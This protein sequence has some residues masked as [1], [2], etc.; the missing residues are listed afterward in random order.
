MNF[1]IGKRIT[2]GFS[3]V[4]AIAVAL[5][6][7]SYYEMGKVDNCVDAIADD[8]MPG[9]IYAGE[10]NGCTR[11]ANTLVLTHILEDSEGMAKTEKLIEENSR[12]ADGAYSSYEKTITQAED[13][14]NFQ[15]LVDARKVF[16][17]AVAKNIEV[18]RK[19]GV[20]TEATYAFYKKNVAPAYE[21]LRVQLDII[22]DFN[23]KYG[24][25]TASLAV[26]TSNSAQKGILSCIA[27]AAVIGALLAFFIVT[28][29]NRALVK[30]ASE[31]GNG[32]TQTA[33]A[34]GQV[35]SS[36]ESLAAG[37][38]EQASSIEETSASIEEMSSMTKA[39]AEHAAKAEA[40][41]SSAM[42]G[43]EK[44]AAAM[45][46]MVK[47]IGDIKKSSDSTAKI[48]KTIDEIAFQTN[49]LAL[50]AAV[51]AARAGEAGKGF[52]VVAEEVRNLAQ[53]SSD[54]A[55]STAAMIEESVKNTNSGVEISQETEKAL[56]EISELAGKVY[57]FL[58][59]ISRASEEQAKGIA[60]INIAVGE[61]ENVTQS[62]AAGA[63]ESASASEELNAQAEEMRRIV[64]EL[65]QLVGAEED[66]GASVGNARVRAESSRSS[67]F[68]VASHSSKNASE[69]RKVHSPQKALKLDDSDL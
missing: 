28:A 30:V 68:S 25:R 57:E 21:K 37:A 15:T 44:G 39:N 61:M 54:A 63:E 18:R 42:R 52:A 2:L 62:N 41:A 49:L 40:M 66:R 23:K 69:A 46:R 35:S 45:E 20:Q 6:A 60:Q 3:A 5:G 24:E 7:F 26:A 67:S 53:R 1:T 33:S 31:L 10:I 9:A 59:Q 56:K 4:I 22:M 55:K 64:G 36:S 19:N 32:A 38:S 27:A 48:V 50:N 14:H 13:R 11:R 29:I 34:A 65:L 12:N 43:A 58:T 47:A 51:E 8:A 17:E 16:I